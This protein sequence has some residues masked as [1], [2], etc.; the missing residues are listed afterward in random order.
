MHTADMFAVPPPVHPAVMALRASRAALTGRDRETADSLL[1]QA[2]R[3]GLSERQLALAVT[4]ADRARQ[5]QT[6]PGA[7]AEGLGSIVTILDRAA[8]RLKW[9]V[10][11]F[12]AEGGRYRLGLSGPASRDPG[13][14]NVTS[15]ERGF[16]SRTY[17]GRI[18]R[19]GVFLPHPGQSA[20]A[21]AIGAALRAFAADPVQSARVYG[22]RFGRCCF[23]G[24]E[25]TDGRS[26]DA[27][28]GPI[29]AEKFGLPWGV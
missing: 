11:R 5:P 15:D 6:A 22:Q 19:D 16:E 8:S 24:L 18:G 10:I 7:R 26:V 21:A 3:R 13:S 4:L 25:L 27:G 23:C 12:E 20:S 17:F 28:Y 9:P 2:S 1:E 29:C 14:V